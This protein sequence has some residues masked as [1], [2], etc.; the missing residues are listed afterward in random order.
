DGFAQEGVDQCRLAAFE[1]SREHDREW[2][3]EAFLENAWRRPDAVHHSHSEQP[4]H[5]LPLQ[6]DGQ[7]LG[8]RAQFL[9]QEFGAVGQF[10]EG[11]RHRA[12]R[13]G[14]NPSLPQKD[15]GN[16]LAFE[17]Y[18]FFGKSRLVPAHLWAPAV[19]HL[20]LAEDS[21][22]R[23]AL[24][25]DRM[26][27]HAFI[28]ADWRALVGIELLYVLVKIDILENFASTAGRQLGERM[29][30]DIEV[31]TADQ[32]GAIRRE[33]RAAEPRAEKQLRAPLQ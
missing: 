25:D 27:H 4:R 6:G 1:I 12:L 26:V 28:E 21:R 2:T 11:R 17:V 9:F 18:G 16:M 8:R 23:D 3:R 10:Q 29:L 33:F 24:A 13:H 31:A 15:P 22:H 19:K 7:L 5:A 30:R 20:A 32:P 14:S